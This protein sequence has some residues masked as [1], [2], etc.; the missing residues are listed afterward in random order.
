MNTFP[1]RN[2]IVEAYRFT[3]GHLGTII[4]LV[5]LPMVLATL[6]NFLPAIG[7]SYNG[8]ASNPLA[9]GT[10]AIE[11]VAVLLLTQLLYAIIYVAVT[12]QALGLRQG[13]AMVHFA[14]GPP[15]F[16]VF[17]ASVL[18]IFAGFASV[19]IYV[20]ALVAVA[21][22]TDMQGGNAAVIAAGGL[23]AFGGGI[24]VIYVMVRLGFFLVPATVI[25]NHV[26]L[27]RSWA[28][29][30]GNVWRIV[31]VLLAIAM[32]LLAVELSA[33]LVLMGREIAAA[34]PAL[35]A[36]D[37]AIQ[38]HMT[39]LGDLIRRHMAEILGITLILVPF[40]LG[41]GLSASAFAYRSMTAG[42][43]GIR[44]GAT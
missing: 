39:A 34:L 15:E 17:G 20:M 44:N 4:G 32:P 12:R 14:L 24:A 26:D 33:I 21:A 38:E 25:E 1:V 5:W 10:N 23:I 16:R 40:N 8:G 18:L 19:L 35:G 41:L 31:L 13:P 29:A 27:G 22:V 3:F 7:G 37:A 2:T 43:E 42:G 9:A 28:L 36:S 6:L 30:R 11:S